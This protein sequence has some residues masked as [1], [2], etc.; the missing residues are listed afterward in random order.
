[1]SNHLRNGG[2]WQKMRRKLSGQQRRIIREIMA[3][4]KKLQA[5]DR[6]QNRIDVIKMALDF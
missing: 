3:T 5:V 6:L 1:L 2:L 4:E